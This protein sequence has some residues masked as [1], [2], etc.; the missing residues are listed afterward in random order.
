VN[1][2]IQYVKEAIRAGKYKASDIVSIDETNVDL[3]LEAGSTLAGRG[4]CT[5][6][7]ATT[8]SS[9]R[10]TVLRGVTMDGEKPP[11]FIIYKGANTP[12]SEIKNEWKDAAAREKFGYPEG[13]HYMVQAKAWMDQA[14]MKE[15]VD[16]IWDPYTKDSRRG[17]CETYLIQD[18]FSVHL[19]AS[20]CN[21]VSRLGTEVE[22]VPGGYT[23]C[24][25][26]LD[27]GIYRSIS[28]NN[29]LLYLSKIQLYIVI[30]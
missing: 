7:C 23:R 18:E 17:G 1:G 28:A 10:C 12:R 8:G 22:I 16:L 6:G 25:H 4:G 29:R 2:Y 13:L 9:A 14:R 11:P 24:V 5:I 3:D 27:K 19:M 26:I 21:A 30:I 15:W 20:L